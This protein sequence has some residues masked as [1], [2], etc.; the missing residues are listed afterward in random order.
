MFTVDELKSLLSKGAD[1]IIDDRKLSG[2]MFQYAVYV[3]G[4]DVGCT[5]CKDNKKE[6]FNNLK[7]QGMSVLENKIERDFELK[8]EVGS[9]PMAL[10]STQFVSNANLTNESA[11]QFL[12]QNKNR[13]K[14]FKKLPDN[15]EA[16]V[17]GTENA[18]AVPKSKLPAADKKPV[19]KA[20][21][22]AKKSEEDSSKKA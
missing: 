6:I 21:Q 11:I 19:K 15:W 12:K 18:V 9:L 4:P 14:H 13:K 10:G 22:K 20:P 16:L 2:R 8:D 7:T 17:D 5:G 1:A 3:F